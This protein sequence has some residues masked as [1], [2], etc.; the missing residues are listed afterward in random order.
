MPRRFTLEAI[1]TACKQQVDL[2]NHAVISDA[3]WAGYISR[4]YG[5][6]YTIVFDAGWQYFEYAT[7]LT[8]DG[9]NELT[10]V[11]DHFSTVNL[12]Y[13][14]DASAG[15]Y[16]DLRELAPQERSAMSGRSGSGPAR[17]FAHV[18]DKLYLYP[19]PPTGQ[20]YQLRYTP[21]PPDV[22][23][24]DGD[25]CL[26]VVTPDG[27]DFLIWSVAVRAMGKTEA[28][29]T[30]AMREREAARERFTNSVRQRSQYSARRVQ[31]DYGDDAEDVRDW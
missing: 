8:T 18:D 4:A 2:E 5:E 26:D 21:Q 29:P 15:R 16:V 10:E 11:S 27:H 9:S 3:E 7:N 19:T 28:D 22:T 13:L 25:D 31:V 24:F 23:T 6:L 14:A 20:V 1:R 17:F 30:L 12:S